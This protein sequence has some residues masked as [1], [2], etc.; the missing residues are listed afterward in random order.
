[1]TDMN[2]MILEIADALTTA[3]HGD[4]DGAIDDLYDLNQSLSDLPL[5]EE[6]KLAYEELIRTAVV[7]VEAFRIAGCEM[8]GQGLRDRVQELRSRD[9]SESEFREC[10]MERLNQV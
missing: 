7:S 5:D 9:L 10:V 8:L 3:M 1:M 4:Q 6:T 2:D